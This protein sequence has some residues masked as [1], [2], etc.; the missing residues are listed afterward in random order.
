M[1]I[2]LE[3][4]G[5]W[6]AVIKHFVLNDKEV[7]KIYLNGVEIFPA[8]APS[9]T[10]LVTITCEAKIWEHVQP[11]YDREYYK[12]GYKWS[13]SH[14][15]AVIRRFNGFDIAPGETR[16]MNNH[17]YDDATRSAVVYSPFVLNV[18]VPDLYWTKPDKYG[19][20]DNGY[21]VLAIPTFRWSIDCG[22]ASTFEYVKSETCVFEGHHDGDDEHFDLSY[23][24]EI[25]NIRT[26]GSFGQSGSYCIYD[27]KTTISH[28]ADMDLTFDYNVAGWQSFVVH[29]GQTYTETNSDNYW[30]WGTTSDKST[31]ELWCAVPHKDNTELTTRQKTFDSVTYGM[32]N[33]S[34]HSIINETKTINYI[35]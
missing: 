1:P 16:V 26:Y 25:V 17:G 11:T 21:D 23:K 20:I 6:P 34:D 9:E 8:Y 5:F 22:N 7:K 29:E 35:T 4:N 32:T 10:F 15:S 14:S 12:V 18:D 30:F 31:Y 24:V 19:D 2:K 27:I 13:L 33:P 28:T 3:G